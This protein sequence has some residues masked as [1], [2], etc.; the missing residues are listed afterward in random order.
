MKIDILTLFPEMFESVLCCSILKRAREKALLQFELHN[1]R[2][3]AQNKHKNA[4]DYPFGGGA[5][6]VMMA[7]P[8]IDCIRSVQ[9]SDDAYRIL[10]TPRGRK[11]TQNIAAELAQKQRL[12]LVCGHYEGI[13]ERIMNYIDDEISIGDYV[14]TGGELPAMVLIDCV[15][16]LVPGVLGSDES[17]RLESFSDGLLEHPQYTRPADLWGIKVPD[18]LLN[19]HHAKIEKWRREQSLIKTLQNRPDLLEQAELSQSDLEFIERYKLN[20]N[21]E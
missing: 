11:L 21:Q 16:R 12:M 8:V 15:V 20:Q 7:Q 4:D 17:A 1:I 2:D 5:G 18:I 14:L 3:H 19:G 6:M 10:M 9:G 13:D